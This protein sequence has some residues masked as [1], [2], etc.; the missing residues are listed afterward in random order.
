MP[1]FPAAAIP[2]LLLAAAAAAATELPMVA[3]LWV[4]PAG[5]GRGE[6]VAA[7][8]SLPAG[9]SAGDAAVVLLAAREEHRPRPRRPA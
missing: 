1:A 9:W 7:V 4:A 5:P 6:A 2:V 3:P 8:L